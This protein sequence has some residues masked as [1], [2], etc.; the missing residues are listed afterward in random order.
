[1]MKLTSF[2]KPL[3]IQEN[4]SRGQCVE[5]HVEGVFRRLS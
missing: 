1:M 2:L 5:S 4:S 3:I